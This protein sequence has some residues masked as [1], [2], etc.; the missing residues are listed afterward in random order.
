ML[1]LMNSHQCFV[2]L[3]YM[4]NI[5]SFVLQDIE[6]TLKPK[7]NTGQEASVLHLSTMPMALRL[8]GHNIVIWICSHVIPN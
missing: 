5:F 4:S 2:S 7:F 8:I 6:C 3:L 1:L